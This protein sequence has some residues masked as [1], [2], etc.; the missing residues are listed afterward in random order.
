MSFRSPPGVATGGAMPIEGLLTGGGAT[1]DAVSG[2]TSAA[3]SAAASL[4]PSAHS[5]AST[6]GNGAGLA[7]SS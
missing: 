5:S 1:I 2:I 7:P 3:T 4:S 6:S